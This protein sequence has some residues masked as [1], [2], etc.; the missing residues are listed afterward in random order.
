MSRTSKS[1]LT[2]P[3]QA[4]NVGPMSGRMNMNRRT[5]L[6]FSTFAVLSLV[7]G[8]LLTG[9]GG[10]SSPSTGGGG[11]GGGAGN[12][13]FSATFSNVAS[14]NATTSAFQATTVQPLTSTGAFTLFNVTGTR[15]AG[16]T[17]RTFALSLAENG[18]IQAGK[19]YTFSATGVASANTLTYTDT[20]LGTAHVWLASGGSAIVDSI[21]GKNYKL[22]LIDVTFITGADNTSGSTGSFTVNGAANVTLP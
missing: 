15:I 11:T 18:P 13:T 2:Q 5:A 3:L 4:S 7:G 10:G 19:T 16:T 9:C 14:T 22:R 1:S 20:D 21:T 6:L 12:G 8:A 17:S